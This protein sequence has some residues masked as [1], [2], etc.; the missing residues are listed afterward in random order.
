MV[1]GKEFDLGDRES[2]E[3]LLATGSVW[4]HHCPLWKERGTE[5]AI[6]VIQ[7][8]NNGALAINY[9]KWDWFYFIWNMQ[10]RWFA[11]GERR[12]KEKSKMTP[13]FGDNEWK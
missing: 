8:R 6:I 2:S 1:Q 11:D 13:D 4:K 12:N 3:R 9:D 5:E 10:L 7:G